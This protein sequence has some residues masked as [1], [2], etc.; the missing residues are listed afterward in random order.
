MLSLR[1]GRRQGL[2]DGMIKIDFIEILTRWNRVLN[3]ARATVGKE[4]IKKEPSSDWKK[5][6]LLAEHSPIRLLILVWKWSGIKS[7]VSVHFVRHKI[8]IEHFVRTQRTDRTGTKRDDIPQNAKVNH[9]CVG[10]AQ[11]IINISRKRLCSSASKE[12]RDAWLLFLKNLKEIEPELYSVSVKE[13]LYR[14]FCPELIC[15]GY[16]ETEEFQVKLKEYRQH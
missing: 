13:C 12:T 3:A 11:T 4:P 5:K 14:G 1:Y 2:W 8:G 15:C 16:V 6:I 9:E 7:W 10:N